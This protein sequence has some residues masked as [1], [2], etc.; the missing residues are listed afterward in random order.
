MTSQS[1]FS[2]FA[3]SQSHTELGTRPRSAINALLT[4]TA[5]SVFLDS[6]FTDTLYGP[7]SPVLRHWLHSV[8]LLTLSAEVSRFHTR[9]R[10]STLVVPVPFPSSV[11]LAAVTFPFLSK[12]E[13]L[14]G[15]IFKVSLTSN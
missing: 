1:S 7:I 11:P 6:N 14:S 9:T 13:I 15:L 2:L 4:R 3:G 10:L 12:T 8:V 5:C